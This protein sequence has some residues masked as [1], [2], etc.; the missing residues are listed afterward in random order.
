[1]VSEWTTSHGVDVH[2][3]LDGSGSGR[4]A[5]IE[6]ALRTAIQDGRLGAGAALPSTRALARDLAVARGTVTAAYEQLVGLGDGAAGD[7]QVAGQRPGRGEGRAGAKAA[8]LDGRA[9]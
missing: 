7:G 5:A 9:Q 2:L 1:M 4:R 6:D 8:V 3:D